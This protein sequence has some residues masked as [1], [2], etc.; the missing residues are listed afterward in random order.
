MEHY[1]VEA[2]QAAIGSMLLG[3]SPSVAEAAGLLSAEDFYRESHRV[4]FSA[5][6][7]LVD[8]GV[9]VDVVT[10]RDELLRVTEDRLEQVGGIP[11]IL[12]IGEMVPTPANLSYYA[13]IVKEHSVKRMVYN[14]ASFLQ[15]DARDW[16]GTAGELVERFQSDAGEAANAMENRFEGPQPIGRA[17]EEGI[18]KLE[19]GQGVGLRYGIRG[20]DYLTYGLRPGELSVVTAR[21]SHGKTALAGQTVFNVARGGKKPLVV[22]LEMTRDEF[23]M[24]LAIPHAGLDPNRVKTQFPRLTPEEREKLAVSCYFVSSLPILVYDPSDLSIESISRAAHLVDHRE[25][26]DLL[27]VDYLQI[28]NPGNVRKDR[29]RQQEIAYISHG[30]KALAKDLRIPVL[31]L[32][33]VNQE[34]ETREGMDTFHEAD[35]VVHLEPTEERREREPQRYAGTVRKHRDGPTGVVDLYFV[36]WE[37]RFYGVEEYEGRLL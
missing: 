34:G 9:E 10:F 31:V 29:S 17:L 27:V 2:E 20:I 30:L 35:V 33:Q 28:I 32:S 8:R 5:L 6:V 11:Y 19:A 13:Q 18:R 15:L 14:M 4:M 36:P 16:E 7:S 24:R 12:Q 1:N 37:T 3:G 23:A 21:S 26:I 25:G 22:S